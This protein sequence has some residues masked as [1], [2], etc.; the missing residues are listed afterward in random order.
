MEILIKSVIVIIYP[1]FLKC[2]Y[3]FITT[4]ELVGLI[5]H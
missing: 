5:K 1:I 3:L 4:T 2:E